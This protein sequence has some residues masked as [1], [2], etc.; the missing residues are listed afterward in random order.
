MGQ[1]TSGEDDFSDCEAERDLSL[2]LLEL[3]TNALDLIVMVW[4]LDDD[5][6]CLSG[7][8]ALRAH[9]AA[10]RTYLD[11]MAMRALVHPNDHADIDAAVHHC[12]TS[13]NQ[14]VNANF[15]IRMPSGWLPVSARGRAMVFDDGGRVTRIVAIL[16]EITD[17]D[18]IA[19][20]KKQDLPE[21]GPGALTGNTG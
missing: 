20:L 7:G 11:S 19:L 18:A 4:Q 5:M 13:G 14:I 21:P 15:R 16:T 2:S 1:G 3:A 17:A 12:L 8:W 10:Q 6:V 9:G